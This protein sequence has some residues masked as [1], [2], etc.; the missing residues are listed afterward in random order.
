M[1]TYVFE[2]PDCE[3]VFEEFQRKMSDRPKTR[4]CPACG[5][6]AR[7]RIT[8]GA[9]FL[10]KGEGFYATDYRSEEYRSKAESE[11]EAPEGGKKKK[12]GGSGDASGGEAKER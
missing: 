5:G 10:F 9:G 2:C 4:K 11:K 7:R 1:P 3:H 12:E 6:R 8:G